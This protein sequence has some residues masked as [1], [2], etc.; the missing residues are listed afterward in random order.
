MSFR[1]I[2][3]IFTLL[4]IIGVAFGSYWVYETQLSNAEALASQVEAGKYQDE[5]DRIVLIHEEVSQMRLEVSLFQEVFFSRLKDQSILLVPDVN[6]GRFNPFLPIGQEPK[7]AA[8]NSLVDD[9][10]V[11][12]VDLSLIIQPSNSVVQENN[13]I[14]DL[15]NLLED[16]GGNLLSGDETI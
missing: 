10:A 16:L 5:L 8:V 11:P 13:L 14:N 9:L 4:V 12:N 15:D 3:R 1:L 6:I 2:K 7:P